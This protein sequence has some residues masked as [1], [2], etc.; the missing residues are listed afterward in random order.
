MIKQ[1]EHPKN[2]GWTLVLRKGKKKHA[3]LVASL[4]LLLY[5]TNLI[6]HGNRVWH[7]YSQTCLLWPSKGTMKY[8]HIRQVVA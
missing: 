8:G 3:P 7:Q 2:Q 5:D 1:H 4:V 6:W